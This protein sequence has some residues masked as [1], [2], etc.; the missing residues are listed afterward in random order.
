MRLD[1]VTYDFD[2]DEWV[3][4]RL[5]QARWIERE[6][7]PPVV[8]PTQGLWTAKRQG[9]RIS[10][11]GF[12]AAG[13]AALPA[14]YFLFLF[15]VSPGHGMG[16]IGFAV[17]FF[18]VSIGVCRVTRF[19]LPG[20]TAVATKD[21]LRLLEDPEDRDTCLVEVTIFREGT[22]IGQDRG[23]AWFDAGRL[24]FNGSG[25]SFAIGGE[26]VQPRRLWAHSL[27][28]DRQLAVPLR[29]PGEVYLKFLLLSAANLPVEHQERFVDRLGAFRCR[30]PQSRGPRQWPPF[31]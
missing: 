1:E 17:F 18:A 19:A 12:W 20:G 4:H 24:M 9:I 31:E 23:V 7:P 6:L 10:S 14:Y 15:L 5:I 30:P 22:A 13:I 11:K 8:A 25:T 21:D 28:I 29:Y 3:A 16:L 26:D 2:R 27:E